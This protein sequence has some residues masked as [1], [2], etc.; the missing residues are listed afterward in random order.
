MP[1]KKR[2]DVRLR[3]LPF[4]A[5]LSCLALSLTSCAL[6]PTLVRAQI[7]P[8]PANL[9]APCDADP[10]IPAADTR[11][12]RLM[13]I[14]QARESAAAVCRDRHAATVRSWPTTSH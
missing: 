6:P 1:C 8:L 4:W 11:L 12:D 2:S 10:D 14:W 13:A 7:D 9:A 3:A 5:M